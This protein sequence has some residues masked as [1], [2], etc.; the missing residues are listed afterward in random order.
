MATPAG[1][2]AGAKVRIVGRI[3]NGTVGAGA[4]DALVVSVGRV[5][6]AGKPA[7]QTRVVARDGTFRLDGLRA[8]RGDRLILAARYSGVTYRDVLQVRAPAGV[9]R[10]RLKI[11][12]ITERDSVISVESDLLTLVARSRDSLEALQLLTLSNSSD[13]TLV[14]SR[15]VPGA[16]TLRLPVPAGVVS[17]LPVRGDRSRGIT[18]TA[19]G[20]SLNDPIPPGDFSISYRYRVA[21]ADGEWTLRRAVLYPTAKLDVAVGPGLEL[22][23]SDLSLREAGTLLAREYRWYR[24]GPF[25]TG[26]S[27]IGVVSHNAA[28]GSGLGLMAFA[29]AALI[30][31]GGGLRLMTVRHRRSRSAAEA[32]SLDRRHLVEA[33]ALLDLAHERGSFSEGEYLAARDRM[34][35]EL[36]QLTD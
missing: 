18:T 29:A 5:S 23:S 28:P 11:H 2:A 9:V 30:V 4:P 26:V 21:M 20:L 3:V 35:R 19:G 7:E 31:A 25:P 15:R 27:V 12:E 16:T 17:I 34:K 13:R 8:T 22:S 33:I 36:T 32:A 6:V 14:A 10:A 24:G 1:A